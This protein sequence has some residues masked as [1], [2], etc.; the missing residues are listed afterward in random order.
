MFIK[1]RM[2]S[3]PEFFEANRPFM[4]FIHHKGLIH[5][6]GRFKPR[7]LRLLRAPISE[8][9]SEPLVPLAVVFNGDS[10]NDRTSISSSD[11]NQPSP[12]WS[13]VFA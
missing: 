13:D 11:D 8:T 1:S 3:E 7:F 9:I 6:A 10:D 12:Y 5:F 4:F 2:L